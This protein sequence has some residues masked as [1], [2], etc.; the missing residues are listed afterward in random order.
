MSFIN[1]LGRF[2]ASV[3]G[4][5]QGK[6]ER[7]ADKMVASSA[8]A[9]RSQFRKTKEDWTKDYQEMREAIAELIRIREMKSDEVKKIIRENEELQ[10]KMNGAIELYKKNP[11]ERYKSAYTQLADKAEK[12]EQRIKELETEIPEGLK[13]LKK[14]PTLDNTIKDGKLIQDFMIQVLDVHPE[15]IHLL[16]TEA[17]AN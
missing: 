5:A 16:A 7:M 14:L 4:L 15:N 3:F 11:D 6:T 10:H 8:D 1:S 13:D 12:N 17:D 9:I 2:F